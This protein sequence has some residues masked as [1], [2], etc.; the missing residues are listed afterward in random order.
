VEWWSA[1]EI[2]G[3]IDRRSISSTEVLEHLVS[4]IERLDGPINSVVQWDL[5]RARAAAREADDAIA[6]GTRLGPLHGVPM[7]IKDSFPT[8]G[9]ITTSGAPELADHVPDA[10]CWPV[11]RL[12]AAGAIPFAKTNLPIFAGDIQSYND[13]YGTTN[14]PHDVT[15][16]CGGSSGGSAAALAMGFT[17]IELGSDIGGS[18]RVPAHYSGVMGHKPSYGIVPAHG[19]I[20]G[21]PGTLTQADLA[22]CGPMARTVDDLALALDVLAGPDRWNAPA[23]RL[24]LPPARAE[25]LADLRIAAW[26]DDA[27]CPV[28]ASTRRVLGALIGSIE[29][30]GG[31]VD[32]EARPGFTLEKADTVFK[33]LLFAALSGEYSYAQVEELAQLAGPDPLSRAR[34]AAAM[35]HREWLAHNERRLQMRERWR[36]FFERFDVILLPV[37]PRGAIPHD[38]SEPQW[39]R[40]V[41]IDG[42]ERPYLDLFGWTGPAGAGMLPATVVP[43][44]LGDDGLPIGVQIVGPYLHDRTTLHAARL[45]GELTPWPGSCPRPAL[46]TTP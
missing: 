13:V 33:H 11:A 43:A 18:I 10:D 28:D 27:Y 30:A 1:G 6:R 21:M 5:D 44:G 42:D 38:H 32:T 22:V 29:D 46:A 16:T 17:P 26:L 4:R 15:R 9:C 8:E 25:S 45:I 35:R 7:T 14:N 39:A 31:R 36:E 19:Q 3:A 24:D 2:A 41:E 20:P 40:T 37:Q 12:R 34:R 23:W